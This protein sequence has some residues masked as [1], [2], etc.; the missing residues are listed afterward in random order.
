M[1]YP[2]EGAFVT[3]KPGPGKSWTASFGPFPPLAGAS[4]PRERSPLAGDS[5]P[6]SV[7]LSQWLA[8]PA[9]AGGQAYRRRFSPQPWAGAYRD[10]A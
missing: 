5:G 6:K 10:K 8:N 1:T 9:L 3:H 2:V 7:G 4:R